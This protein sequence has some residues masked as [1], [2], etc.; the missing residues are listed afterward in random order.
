M[1]AFRAFSLALAT[2][3]PHPEERSEAERLEGWQHVLLSQEVI[4]ATSFA[5]SFVLPSFETLRF[6]TLLRM[7]LVGRPI[8]SIHGRSN[9]F[10]SSQHDDRGI[11]DAQH[12]AAIAGVPL[13]SPTKMVVPDHRESVG[14]LQPCENL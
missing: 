5:T 14:A 12:P 10:T 3:P 7:R 8:V 2:T 6:A 11:S 4:S 1:F 13:P 9:R